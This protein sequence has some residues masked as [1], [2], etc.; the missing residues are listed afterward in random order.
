MHYQSVA[1]KI[2]FKCIMSDGKIIFQWIKN[3][4]KLHYE[5]DVYYFGIHGSLLVEYSGLC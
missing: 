1:L 4:K 3:Q 5:K 2:K